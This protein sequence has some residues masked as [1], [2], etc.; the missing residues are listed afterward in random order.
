MKKSKRLLALLLSVMFIFGAVCSVPFTASAAEIELE[1]TGAYSLR[2]DTLKINGQHMQVDKDYYCMFNPDAKES[3]PLYAVLDTEEAGY[4]VLYA[5]NS[6][7]TT[8]DNT[9]TIGIVDEKEILDHSMGL[10]N[11]EES[12]LAVRLEAN[13]R[14]YVKLC[15]NYEQDN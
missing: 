12:E 6:Q 5:R 2:F 8:G 1:E 15:Y 3:V 4:Y 13:T 9:V 11:G 10:A 7:L 14:Y